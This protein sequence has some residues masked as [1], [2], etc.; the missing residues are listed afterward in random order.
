MKLTPILCTA[1]L[2]TASVRA[3]PIQEPNSDDR[4]D[5]QLAKKGI[6]AQAN[7]D[8]LAAPGEVKRGNIWC[9]LA[10]QPCSKAKRDAIGLVDADE[11]EDSAGNSKQRPSSHPF[12]SI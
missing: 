5:V 3:L 2:A 4:P 12:A 7:A 8:A 6:A 10:G 9:Y 1:I 11:S